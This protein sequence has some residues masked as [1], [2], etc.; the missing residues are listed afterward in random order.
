[1]SN[2]HINQP[3]LLTRAT[4]MGS[5]ENRLSGQNNKT[6]IGRLLNEFM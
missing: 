6:L 1:L 4:G 5:S 3:T 2:I